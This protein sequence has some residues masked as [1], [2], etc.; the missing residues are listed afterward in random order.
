MQ[1]S[2]VVPAYNESDKIT[3][4]LTKIVGF[5]RDFAE[6]FEVIVVDDGS[7]DDTVKLVEE[8]TTSY[9]EIKLIKNPHRGKGPTVLTGIRN[10]AGDFIYMCDADLS[11]PISEIKKLSTWITEQG[12]DIVIA[13]REGAG[14]VRVDE[15]FYRHFIGRGFNLGVQLLALPGI[16]DSQCGFKLFKGSIAKE[17]ASKMKVYTDDSSEMKQAF[18][19]AFDVEM[20]FIARYLGYKIKELP[21][22][23]NYVGHTGRGLLF[24][25]IRMGIDVLRIRLNGLKG[26]YK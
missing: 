19:G 14:A 10:A 18:F 4:S 13:S 26:A 3:S 22:L 8:Y 20:L 2:I 1:Y 5:M 24:N 15:P 23:W 11:T 17:V 16:H 25:G 9:P 21:V 7:A 12:Y 6:S